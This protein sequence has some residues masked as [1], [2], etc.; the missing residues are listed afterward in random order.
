[1]KTIE[2]TAPNIKCEGCA[3][4]ITTALS[5]I[6]GVLNVKVDV[7]AKQVSVTYDDLIVSESTL[8]STLEESGYPASPR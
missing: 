4:T 8:R 2:Y 5:G 1:M 7:P 3:E 6:G